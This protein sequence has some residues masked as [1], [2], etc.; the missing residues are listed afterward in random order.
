MEFANLP[1]SFWGYI[2]ETTCYILNK[3]LSKSIDKTPYEIWTRRRPLLSH[4]RIWE[5]P[6]Y[7][8]YL[9]IDKLGPKFDRYLFVGYPKE[10][11]GYYST[12][13]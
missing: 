1:I 7:V 5:C 9:K 10:T 8:K 6:T 11:K 4:L 13:L 12:S 2:L 3:I